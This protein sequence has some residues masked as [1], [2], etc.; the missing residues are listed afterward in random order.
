MLYGDE[1]L[2]LNVIKTTIKKMPF[3]RN[4]YNK[5]NTL[6]KILASEKSIFLTLMVMK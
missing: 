3:I 5:G 2:M 1:V 6:G 4:Y